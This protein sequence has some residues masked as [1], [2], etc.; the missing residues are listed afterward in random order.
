MSAEPRARHVRCPTDMGGLQASP[1]DNEHLTGRVALNALRRDADAGRDER[2]R[3]EHLR[4]VRLILAAGV[5]FAASCG[6]Y[7]AM[8]RASAASLI[9]RP[10]TISSRDI[11]RWV[12]DATWIAAEL[13]DAPTR[14]AGRLRRCDVR[15]NAA[16]GESRLV[17]GSYLVPFAWGLPGEQELLL[18]PRST[19]FVATIEGFPD[20]EV[21]TCLEL[22]VR[23]VWEGDTSSGDFQTFISLRTCAPC[24]TTPGAPNPERR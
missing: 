12:N 19:L 4:Y 3:N 11:R 10:A 15:D 13:L 6:E 1:A 17:V 22:D 23:R 21:D 16:R 18:P 8:K 20:P 9:Q 24:D 2:V 14:V 7:R 5:L